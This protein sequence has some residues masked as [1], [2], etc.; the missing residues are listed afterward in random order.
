MI[1]LTML[2]ATVLMVA[3][4]SFG[5][6]ASVHSFQQLML[7][8]GQEIHIQPISGRTLSWRV[9]SFDGDQLEVERR[10]WNFRIEK[11]IFTEDSVRRIKAHDSPVN[12]VLIGTGAG[13][14]G[15]FV[16]GATCNELGCV[17]PFILSIG[18]GPGLGKAI[19]EAMERTIYAPTA[20]TTVTISPL[21]GRNRF[22]V[23]AQIRLGAFH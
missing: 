10:R 5:Q 22:G 3:Q 8:S 23:A 19:D 15:A 7:E 17:V 21:L 6:E 12:G 13:L 2:T 20:G 11:R 9:A 4:T 16:I 1:R 18:L 14:L